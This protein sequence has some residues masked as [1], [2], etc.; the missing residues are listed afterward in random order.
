MIYYPTG[1]WLEMEWLYPVFLMLFLS[2]LVFGYLAWLAKRRWKD[3]RTTRIFSLIS[4][5]CTVAVMIM[6]LLY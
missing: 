6:V 3:R 1:T 2:A 5:L 4:I